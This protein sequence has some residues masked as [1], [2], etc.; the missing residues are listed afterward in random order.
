MRTTILNA[1]VMGAEQYR[2][3]EQKEGQSSGE[4]LGGPIAYVPPSPLH[5]HP[6]A[7]LPGLRRGMSQ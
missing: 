6:K 3:V 4:E 7:L 2:N 1:K 5:M